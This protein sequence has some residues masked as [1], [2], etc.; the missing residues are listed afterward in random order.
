ML[1]A[2]R[3]ATFQAR[4]HQDAGDDLFERSSCAHLNWRR[5]IPS[6]LRYYLPQ[7]YVRSTARPLLRLIAIHNTYTFD[8]EAYEHA[9]GG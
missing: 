8:A 7:K 6:V 9:G 4:I 5:R 3:T 2:K 1:R